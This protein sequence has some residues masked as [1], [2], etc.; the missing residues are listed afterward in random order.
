MTI[1]C[2]K[3]NKNYQQVKPI[4]NR[5]MLPVIAALIIILTSLFFYYISSFQG[6]LTK[7]SHEKIHIATSQ[8]QE[9]LVFQA[10]AISAVVEVLIKSKEVQNGLKTK[11]REG[12]FHYFS[13]LFKI[14]RK[15]HAIT[16]F[17]FHT[18]ERINL[19]RIHKP[20]K[21]GE[22]INR[23]TLLEAERTGKSVSGIE[24][25]TFGTFT[26]RVVCPV[27]S[28]DKLIGY[29]EL[30]KEIEDILESIKK[31]HDVELAVVIF[32]DYVDREN[33]EAG[34]EM[35]GRRGDW[36]Y[37]PQRV[38]TYSTLPD[39]RVFYDKLKLEKK[40]HSH[41]IVLNHH[42][43]DIFWQFKA[44]S[45]KDVSGVVHGDIITI[46]DVSSE[47]VSF[48]KMQIWLAALSVFFLFLLFVFLHLILKRTDKI[49]QEQQDSLFRT[50]EHLRATL[51]SITEGVISTDKS[52]RI[53][54]LNIIAGELTGWIGQEALGRDVKEVVNLIN[55]SKNKGEERKTVNI[56]LEKVIKEGNSINL[57]K[58]LILVSQN[59][60]EYR[61]SV[62]C[63]PLYNNKEQISGVV[64]VF[65][66]MSDEYQLKMDIR[67]QEKQSQIL[68]EST[69]DAIMMLD[70][71]GFFACNPATLRLFGVEN[72]KSFCRLHPADLSPALQPDGKVSLESADEQIA[73]ALQ[74]GH[75]RF[76]WLHK[77]V[78]TDQNFNAEVLLTSMK[79]EGRK[80][81]QASVRDITARQE[82]EEQLRNALK[83]T[84]R[85]NRL[86]AGREM[87]VV[88]MK[89]EVNQLL[90]GRGERVRY[91][92]VE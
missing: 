90:A 67:N 23:F 47:I 76:N 57:D 41:E 61:V 44:T 2:I 89:K 5:L 64:M 84:K 6:F 27:F 13:P 88:E 31:D 28:D 35:L 48:K 26:L 55:T 63:S 86:M 79:I 4:Y 10:S 51:G 30:G 69:S 52:G 9:H 42:E 20:E 38:L 87:R 17:Y 71:N 58:A 29:L 12:L 60:D 49:I 39:I 78:D 25:G 82:Y 22:L 34:M 81:L 19:L 77:R 45:L 74:S 24:L 92:S 7:K 59:K 85:L 68:Y 40:E 72:E 36:D 66:D 33:W 21:N 62:N 46:N 18:P 43:Q 65:R 32:K 1:P 15:K 16:H 53:L 3:N 83:E 54:Q 70:E 37:L 50:K 75:N 11:D 8:F 80:V 73:I 14:L 91:R 56:P